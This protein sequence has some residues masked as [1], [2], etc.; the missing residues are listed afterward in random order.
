[1]LDSVICLIPN[2]DVATIASHN[3]SNCNVWQ[4]PKAGPH[5]LQHVYAV[6]SIV[7]RSQQAVP[8]ELHVVISS[9]HPVRT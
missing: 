5:L 2:F 1:M 9:L 4:V 3:L 6:S 8:V 7:P